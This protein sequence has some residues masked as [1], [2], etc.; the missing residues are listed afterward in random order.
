MLDLVMAARTSSMQQR[1]KEP[2]LVVYGEAT[3]RKLKAEM[4][5]LAALPNVHSVEMSSG[6]LDIHEEFPDEVAEAVRS[7]F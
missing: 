6:N 3:A 7:F 5:A 1:L 4:Q 2:I